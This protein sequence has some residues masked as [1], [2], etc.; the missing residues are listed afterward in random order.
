M[1]TIKATNDKYPQYKILA[2]GYPVGIFW[3]YTNAEYFAKQYAK[4]HNLTYHE[5][6]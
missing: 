2:N 6:T 4:S 3:E 5:Q 1:V